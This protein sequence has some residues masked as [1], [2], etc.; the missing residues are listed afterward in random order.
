MCLSGRPGKCEE[1]E[2]Q[3]VIR[4]NFEKEA[5]AQT[6]SGKAAE[7]DKRRGAFNILRKI[8]VRL[9][10]CYIGAAYASSL[11]F[12]PCSGDSCSLAGTLVINLGQS[13]KVDGDTLEEPR[14]SYPILSSEDE[15]LIHGIYQFVLFAVTKEHPAV[16]K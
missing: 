9:L 5:W 15:L 14:G 12:M 2:R 7:K 16:N 11:A 8:S 6:Y 1:S 4:V 3:L 10:E 13:L